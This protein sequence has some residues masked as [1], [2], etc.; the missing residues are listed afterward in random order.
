MIS[1]NAQN[2]RAIQGEPPKREPPVVNIT[3]FPEI[4]ATAHIKIRP[5]G[6][7]DMRVFRFI[8]KTVCDVW[9]LT[10]PELFSER[11]SWVIS[12]PRHAAWFLI[13][14]HT[15]FSTTKIGALYRDRDHTSIMYGIKANPKH[16]DDNPTFRAKF[17]EASAAILEAIET[18]EI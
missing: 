9:G 13:R 7:K 18:G 1:Y 11:R 16:L 5:A 14:Q 10:A 2:T 4:G 3:I 17:C 6:G 15:S 12:W 8:N